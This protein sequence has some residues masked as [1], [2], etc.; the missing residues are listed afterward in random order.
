MDMAKQS[1][2]FEIDAANWQLIEEART[3]RR[4]S[5]V[6]IRRATEAF[7]FSQNFERTDE[8]IAKVKVILEGPTKLPREFFNEFFGGASSLSHA[9][10]SNVFL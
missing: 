7:L 6:D 8:A 9:G 2:L 4:C 5:R 1:E 3:E 10:G